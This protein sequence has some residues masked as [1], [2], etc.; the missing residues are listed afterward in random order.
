[1]G[2]EARETPG[3]FCA[4]Q[5]GMTIHFD[6]V[7][8]GFGSSEYGAGIFSGSKSNFIQINISF[9]IDCWARNQETL[10]KPNVKH[11][12]LICL[13]WRAENAPLSVC[14]YVCSERQMRNLKWVVS[15]ANRIEM[16]SITTW[17]ACWLDVGKVESHGPFW[18]FLSGVTRG[19]LFFP[20]WHIPS[21]ESKHS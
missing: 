12:C 15:S 19:D 3:S 17:I 13:I 21:L 1:M 7:N 8:T 2:D 14:V 4:E 5:I 9:T 18:A 20:L 16:F 6:H 11:K 10:L